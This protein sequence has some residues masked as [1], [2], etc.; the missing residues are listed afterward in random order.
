M[1]ARILQQLIAKP[2]HTQALANALG[3]DY[4]TALYHA[5]KMQKEG[6][7]LKEGK[8]YGATYKVT[9]NHEQLAAFHSLQREMG[10]SLKPNAEEVK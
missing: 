1:R 5:E 6:W 7:I 8:D 10:Q 9:F 2:M 4:K 3:I